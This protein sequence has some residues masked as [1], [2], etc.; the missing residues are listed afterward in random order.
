M[1]TEWESNK[2]VWQSLAHLAESC[3]EHIRHRRPSSKMVSC[4]NVMPFTLIL[5]ESLPAAQH[6]GVYNIVGFLCT[7]R[8]CLNLK[9]L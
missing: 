1:G 6:C 4:T 8:S 7:C 3:V 5:C 2:E 9:R